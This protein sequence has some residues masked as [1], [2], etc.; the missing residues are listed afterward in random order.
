M[1]G[2]ITGSAW[3]EYRLHGTVHGIPVPAGM[4]EG[5]AFEQPMWTPSTKAEQGHHDENI[6]PNRARRILGADVSREVERL[7][8]A[9]YAK[10]ADYA[11]ARGIILA[12][13]KFEFGIDEASGGRIVLA[14]EV[15]TPDSSRFWAKANYEV[16]KSQM[17][18]DKQYLR[19]WLT[20]NKLDG[21]EGV[22]MPP[23]VVANTRA[24]YIEAYEALTQRKWS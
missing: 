11:Y 10:A 6:S 16:G 17:S 12:D 18:Y 7:S 2:Y 20:S 15:L 8:L 13:T 24:R 5:A 19:D 22:C 1:R 3:K 14:D 9:L 4:Q 23:E 21:V